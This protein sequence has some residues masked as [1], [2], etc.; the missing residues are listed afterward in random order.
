MSNDAP[1]RRR[2]GS[3]SR[4]RFLRG[5]GAGVVVASTSRSLL[6][7]EAQAQSAST[8]QFVRLR[9]DRFGRIFPNLPPFFRSNTAALR[10]AL[11]EIGRPGG[12][13][14]A[15]DEL[16]DGGEQA[17]INLIAD[18]ALNVDNPNNPA[19]GGRAAQ[20]AGSTFIGQFIDHDLTFDQTSPL[21]RR[22][23]PRPRPT[24][25]THGSTSTPSMATGRAGIP[26]ST[27]ALVGAGTRRPS[28]G[29]SPP[30]PPDISRT[31]RG[32]RT[33]PPSSPIRATTR[34]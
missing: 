1:D 10:A 16:G 8:T 20:T 2:S 33:A 30:T 21:G 7:R 27:S 13:M 4:R 24:P 23:N 22:P 3:I 15:Q 28:C 17:A 19:G 9:E 11:R 32:E 34:T 25:A 29:S 18:P 26:S 12:I 31:C 5:V 6:T 14:D